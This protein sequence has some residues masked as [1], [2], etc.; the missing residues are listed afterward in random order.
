[1]WENVAIAA[2]GFALTVLT[3]VVGTTWRLR[4][5][6]DKRDAAFIEMLSNHEANDVR[7]FNE[8]NGKIADST[9]M[10]ATSF[11]DTGRAIREHMHMME[12]AA[13]REKTANLDKFI[14]RESFFEV[15]KGI[16]S[17]FDRIDA[18]IAGAGKPAE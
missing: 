5:A 18:F 16:N 8:V 10:L 9:H 3:T 1:M 11:G 6:M 17:R 2:A 7:R 14:R 12:L 15:I 4:G 13:E